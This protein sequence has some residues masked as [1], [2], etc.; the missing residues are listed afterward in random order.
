MAYKIG[1][2][3]FSLELER[4]KRTNPEAIVH[5]GNA[6]EGALILNQMRSMGMKQRF[7]RLRQVS[8]GRV[9][10]ACG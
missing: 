4:L 9:R 8:F 10:E 7:L 3:D 1:Q 2:T 5:W 6:T